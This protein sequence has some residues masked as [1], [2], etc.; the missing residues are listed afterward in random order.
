MNELEKIILGHLLIQPKLLENLDIN[1]DFFKDQKQ[2]LIFK[3]IQKG[4]GDLALIA[5]KINIEGISSYLSGLLDGIPKTDS[6]NLSRYVNKVKINRLSMDALK[7]ISNGMKTGIFDHDKIGG[8]YQEIKSLDSFADGKK[9]TTLLSSI[10][11]QRVEWLWQ[12]YIPIGRLSM[13]SGDPGDGKTFLALDLTARVTK[14][15]V[16]PDGSKVGKLGRAFY[17]SIEDKAADTL[18]PRIDSLGGDSS[19]ITILNPEFE[20]FL[21]FAEKGGLRLFEDEVKKSEGLRLCVIDPILDFSGRVNPN[22]PEQVR[23]LLAPLSHIAEKYNFALILIA[24]LNKAQSMSA[25]YRTGGSTGAWLGKCRAAFMIF[26][27]Q[28]DKKQRF[29]APLKSN[30]AATDPD[31]L[32]FR[33]IESRLEFEKATEDMDI[34][35]YINPQLRAEAQESSF[36][37]RWL[38]EALKDGPV[39]SKEIQER[40]IEEAGIAKTTL[41]RASHKLK[42]ITKMEGFGKFRTSTWSLLEKENKQ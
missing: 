29:F 14:G 1:K 3:E 37:V 8:F 20:D 23:A 26:R 28:D 22:A 35:D 11:S 36:A 15:T 7:L 6:K 19:K 16:W 33:I 13:I 38:K 24:H 2:R 4:N 25:L 32:S 39:D 27:N 18:R 21:C 34:D 31:R 17:L 5:E 30:L 42:V 10:E 9:W 12:N 41:W 40:A